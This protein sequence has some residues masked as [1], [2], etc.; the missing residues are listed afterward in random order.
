MPPEKA[1]VARIKPV[2]VRIALSFQ[3]P[4]VCNVNVSVHSVCY[5]YKC[6]SNCNFCCRYCNR[7]E[8]KCL[9]LTIW[10]VS[11][12][13]NQVEICRI[14]YHFYAKKHTDCISLYC[15][16]ID[17]N[18]KQCNPNAF[19]HRNDNQFCKSQLGCI[20]R[21]DYHFYAKKHTD[22]ISLYCDSIDSNGKQCHGN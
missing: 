6:Q 21:I 22:C 11:R 13:C 9:S 1:V 2:K 19:W 12:K 20:C 17:S 7:K 5:N 4:K 3:A 15:D 14:D 16:S 18:G 8:S 10:Y